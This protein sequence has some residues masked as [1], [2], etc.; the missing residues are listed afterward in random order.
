MMMFSNFG[1][2][3]NPKPIENIFTMNRILVLFVLFFSILVF[4][5]GHS[6]NH[7]ISGLH[8]IQLNNQ[9]FTTIEDPRNCLAVYSNFCGPSY[10]RGLWWSGCYGSNISIDHSDPLSGK[11]IDDVDSCC[12]IHDHCCIHNRGNC[13]RCDSEIIDCLEKKECTSDSPWG[14]SII[15]TVMINFFKYRGETC[16]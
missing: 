11:P 14:C 10:S 15:R 16:C 4:T 6:V 13:S 7:I 5:H 3:K 12:R 8:N 1:G 2:K 9:S